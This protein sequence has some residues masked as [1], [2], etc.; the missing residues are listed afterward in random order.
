MIFYSLIKNLIEIIFLDR[1]VLLYS[2]KFSLKWYIKFVI[3][4][5]ILEKR[6]SSKVTP[7]T[8]DVYSTAPV[9]VAL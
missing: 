8:T 4:R 7:H 1:R 6:T 9:S 5:L 2:E 3:L